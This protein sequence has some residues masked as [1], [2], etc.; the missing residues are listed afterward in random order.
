MLKDL[1]SRLRLETPVWLDRAFRWWLTEIRGL[2]SPELLSFL[3]IPRYENLLEFDGE[4]LIVSDCVSGM[5]ASLLDEET[6]QR[7]LRE[8][9]G[10]RSLLKRLGR[11]QLRLRIAHDRCLIRELRVPTTNRAQARRIAELQGQTSL[12]FEP[13]QV[14][15]AHAIADPKNGLM[16]LTTVIVK[17]S[18]IERQLGVLARAGCCPD[19]VDAADAEGNG[20]DVDLLESSSGRGISAL[21]AP[22][23]LILAL[24]LALIAL[25]LEW[26]KRTSALA[27]L[28]QKIAEVKAKVDSLV[29]K[30]AEV[31]AVA[32]AVSALRRKRVVEPPAVELWDE[33][34]RAVP[35]TA[36]ISQLQA[37]KNK[38][39][40][41]GFATEA[42]PL[43]G[44]L[45]QEPLF[46]LVA[47]S[48]PVSFDPSASAERFGIGFELDLAGPTEARV[49]KAPN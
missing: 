24:L 3:A 7:Y 22:L 36:W 42:A 28:D 41:S 29:K 43:V 31:N 32:D 44:I 1:S 23:L 13:G 10:A 20:Y 30:S 45:E 46:R 25:Q 47:F 12:P 26:N 14:V 33:L 11:P 40:V 38:V 19:F 6:Q 16:R 8:N 18:T 34:S 17:R 15:C 37:T 4:V 21:A 9:Y 35:D 2:F 49:E 39:S 48:S 5:L 27:E